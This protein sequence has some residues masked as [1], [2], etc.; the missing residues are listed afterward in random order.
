[1]YSKVIAACVLVLAYN[2]LACAKY[3]ESGRWS[4]TDKDNTCLIV[5]MVVKANFTY[6]TS[7]NKTKS[8]E[9]LIPVNETRVISGVNASQCSDGVDTLL[10]SWAENNFSMRFE[11]NKTDENTKFYDLTAFVINLNV[12]GLFND[13]AVNQSVTL[14]YAL[15]ADKIYDKPTNFSYHCNRDQELQAT[16]GSIVV[17]KLQFEAFKHGNSSKFSAAKDCDS[18]ISPDIVPIAVGISLIALIVVVL[19]AYIV[20]R[21]RQQARGYLNIM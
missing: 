3:P 14:K 21:R 4:V 12:S 15:D 6:A 11:Q 9:Y 16:G 7:D 8:V 2:N 1:M 18:N 5:Q 20:G 17:S 13:S 10:V 19:I